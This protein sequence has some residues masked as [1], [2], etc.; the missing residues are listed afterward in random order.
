MLRAYLN[1]EDNFITRK[2]IFLSSIVYPTLEYDELS[3]GAEFLLQEEKRLAYIEKVVKL[4]RQ[5]V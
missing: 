2:T 5:K 3:T 4:I 1:D